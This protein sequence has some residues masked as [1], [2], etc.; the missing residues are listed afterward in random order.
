[1][2][3]R[4][5]TTSQR[6][7]LLQESVLTNN[8]RHQAGASPLKAELA[9]VLMEPLRVARSITQPILHIVLNTL[10]AHAFLCLR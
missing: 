3:S 10:Y 9:T 8:F 7:L 4:P 5:Q 1:M 6:I 2:G